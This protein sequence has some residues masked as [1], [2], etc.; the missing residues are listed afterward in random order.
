MVRAE[1]RRHREAANLTLD[2]LSDRTEALGFRISRVVLGK[3]EGGFRPDITL[4]EL[5]V[6]AR[7][8]GVTPPSL[9]PTDTATLEITP[10][11]PVE[12]ALARQWWAGT[13]ALP[14]A[15]GRLS[16]GEEIEVEGTHARELRRL[17]YLQQHDAHLATLSGFSPDERLLTLA[18]QPD[19]AG[20]V[21]T[22]QASAYREWKQ[23][24]DE[25]TRAEQSDDDAARGPLGVRVDS[26]R[27]LH[28]AAARDRAFVRAVGQLRSARRLLRDMGEE[29]PPVP[30]LFEWIDNREEGGDG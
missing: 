28:E 23:A 15:V 17:E 24:E 19:A 9:L 11:S 8:L 18:S 27:L 30:E 5:L 14:T 1:I 26:L 2:G 3:I 25:L 4:P 20:T 12:A 16:T 10:D 13:A 21:G 6:L 29:P 22:M 7:A